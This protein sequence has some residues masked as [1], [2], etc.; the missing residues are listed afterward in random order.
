MKASLWSYK[1]LYVFD[2]LYVDKIGSS[3][4]FNKIWSNLSHFAFYNVEIILARN[5]SSV[6]VSGGYLDCS[7]FSNIVL[8]S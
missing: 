4:N 5:V 3:R 1:L 6:L 8:L 2:I 7:S